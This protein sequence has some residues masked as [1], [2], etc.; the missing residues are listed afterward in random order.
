[1]G[2][3]Y[4]KYYNQNNLSFFCDF[5]NTD[6]GRMDGLENWRMCQ[7]ADVLNSNVYD[8]DYFEFVKK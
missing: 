5:Y 3:Q 1:M 2:K 7:T 4:L 6:G 8:N